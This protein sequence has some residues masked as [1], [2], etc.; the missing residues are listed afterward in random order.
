MNW[1]NASHTT[2][3]KTHHSHCDASYYERYEYV[4]YLDLCIG[5]FGVILHIG[6]LLNGFDYIELWRCGRRFCH[7]AKCFVLDG[8]DMILILNGNAD[9][10]MHATI[11]RLYLRILLENKNSRGA[12][13]WHI[14]HMEPTMSAPR[15]HGHRRLWIYIYIRCVRVH[16]WV[17]NLIQMVS[18][19]T[20]CPMYG[21][22]EA[23]L[24]IIYFSRIYSGANEKKRQY[25]IF[26]VAPNECSIFIWKPNNNV[27][28]HAFFP[29]VNS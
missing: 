3:P 7:R 18:L 28:K 14:W 19:S 27:R 20:V 15:T 26:V 5:I 9:A 1:I 6:I 10:K 2:H 13:F 11:Q 8:L 12:V 29:Q 16:V 23:S 21:L 25:S 24:L 17:V 4:P 22:D